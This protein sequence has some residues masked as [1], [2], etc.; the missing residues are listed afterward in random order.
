MSTTQF[1]IISTGLLFLFIFLS[2]FW[3]SR[4]GKPY[5]VI[6]FTLHKLIALGALIFLGLAVYRTHQ[7]FPLG[8]A[9]MIAVGA[10]AVCFIAT[11]V[12]GGL[13]SIGKPMPAVISTIHRLLPYA[14]VLSTASVLY[15]LLAVSREISNA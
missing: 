3:L 2:G 12:T 5:P 10:A 11:I 14:T 8:P 9:Q 13:T 1:R 4:A 6:V 15:L 7:V